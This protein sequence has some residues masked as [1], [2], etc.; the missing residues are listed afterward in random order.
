MRRAPARSFHGWI[1][2][3]VAVLMAAA[4]MPGQTVIVSLFNDSYR[5][6]LGLSITE[7]SVAYT[8]GTLF[9]AL[10]I[11][12][13][14]RMADRHGLRLVTGGVV[15]AFALALGLLSQVRGP[16]M[17]GFGFF[18]IRCL[19]QGCLAM[20]SGHVIAMWFERRLGMAH[21]VVSI[22]GFAAASAL[23]AQPT[24]WLITELGWQATLG[25]L[26]GF[27]LVL[28]LPAVATVFRNRPEDVGQ[29]LDGGAAADVDREAAVPAAGK[30]AD[31]AFTVREAVRTRAYW[32]CT[33]TMV[34]SGLIGTALIFHMSS[35]LQTAGLDGAPRQVALAVQPWPIAFGVAT[36]V[37]GWLIDRFRP[38]P[39]LAIGALLLGVATLVCLAA[40]RGSV[41]SSM[42]VALMGAGM[43]LFGASQAAILGVASPTIARY[44]GRTH[45]GAIRGTVSAAGVAS[46]GVGPLLAGVGYELAGQSFTALLA[47]FAACAV[48]LTVG[49][50]LLRPPVRR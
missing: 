36:L 10:P 43:G 50:L 7:L 49:A 13:V 24:A 27:V 32:I 45:H 11:S 6:A 20:L 18:L 41:S 33:L 38:A 47:G 14:G 37:V 22:G 34:F 9:A 8:I 39:L 1:M 25:V 42:T 17:L 26:A 29:H 35:M 16:I 31:P 44:F 30:P 48:P 2:L 5:Q 46:T 4:T 15:L 28:T 40:A 3:G 23:M 12:W 19:G 21:A